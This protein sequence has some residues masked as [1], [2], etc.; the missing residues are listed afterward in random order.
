MKYSIQFS[1][2]GNETFDTTTG[3]DVGKYIIKCRKVFK[4]HCL[5]IR[6]IIIVLPYNNRF[7]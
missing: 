3:V 5:K 2:F 4:D 7:L 6:L 1:V